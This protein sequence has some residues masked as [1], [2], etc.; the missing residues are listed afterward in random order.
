MVE[1]ET[2]KARAT[3]IDVAKLAGVSRATA[4][5]VIRND[6]KISAETREK[7][8]AAIKTLGYVRNLTAARMRANQ[9]RLIGV[10]VPNLVN[11]FFSEFFAGIERVAK[12]AGLAVLLANSHD[13]HATQLDVITRMRE[14]GVDGLII[15]PAT[16]TC[17]GMLSFDNLLRMPVVQ[18]LRRV[19]SDMDYIGPDYSQGMHAAVDHLASLGHRTIALAINLLTH[20]ASEERLAGF[21]AAMSKWGLSASSILTVSKEIPEIP[22]AAAALLD[23]A[24]RPTATICANDL[25][26]LGLLAGL[27]DLGISVGPDHALVGFD[28]VAQ[29]EIARPRLTSV[30][31][32][33]VRI[34]EQAANRLLARLGCRMAPAHIEV[35][36]SNLVVRESSSSQFSSR[37][38]GGSWG[39]A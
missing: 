14:H 21:Q 3:L 19:R 23:L 9:N 33:P 4:S 5:L 36:D 15:C 11:P 22:S 31:T 25:I 37:H 13:E 10:V 12:D 16:N 27:T 30:A 38:V 2:E 32:H 39:G 24:P 17:A 35:M 6:P 26:A 28:D 8:E 34:G 29:A 20:S 18:A 7:V 1:G